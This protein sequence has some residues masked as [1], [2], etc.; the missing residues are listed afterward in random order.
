MQSRPCPTVT[1]GVSF[2]FAAAASWSSSCLRLRMRTCWSSSST[3]F[4]SAGCWTSAVLAA[5]ATGGLAGGSALTGPVLRAPSGAAWLCFSS[6]SSRR[7]SFSSSSWTRCSR[8]ASV[9]VWASR[10]AREGRQPAS[11][12]HC[13]RERPRRSHR[14]NSSDT[15]EKILRWFGRLAS[16]TCSGWASG[17]SGRRVDDSA[18]RGARLHDGAT[19]GVRQAHFSMT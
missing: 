4:C 7:C 11:S 2:A 8:S 19:P 5:G 3:C 10:H 9:A 15:A 14:K 12:Q 13:E 16:K 18:G 6:F 1:T 17:I